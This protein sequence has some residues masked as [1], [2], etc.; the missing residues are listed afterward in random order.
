MQSLKVMRP[1]EKMIFGFFGPLPPTARGNTD[2]LVTVYLGSRDISL[3][4]TVIE[5]G[6]GCWENDL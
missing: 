1:G 2:L 4:G 6:N 3:T 5:A